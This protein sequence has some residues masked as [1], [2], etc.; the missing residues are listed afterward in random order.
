MK[1]TSLWYIEGKIDEHI[2]AM[3]I[4][5]LMTE[6]Q[7]QVLIMMVATP[8]GGITLSHQDSWFQ[9]A[10]SK[11]NGY[12]QR[13]LTFNLFHKLFNDIS[14]NEIFTNE[15]IDRLGTLGDDSAL[16]ARRNRPESL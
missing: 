7:P 2:L 13:P 4:I 15:T 16:F 9:T 10:G 6:I 5:I 3:F 14:H 1:V 8:L 11:S 12:L